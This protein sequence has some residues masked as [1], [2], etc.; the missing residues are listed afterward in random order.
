MMGT[1]KQKR[2]NEHRN[3]RVDDDDDGLV[4]GE[5]PGCS[6]PNDDDE[7]HD[8]SLLDQAP[9]ACANGVDD[10]RDRLIDFH[11]VPPSIGI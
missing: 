6:G 2:Q 1:R 8:R 11:S 7:R 3:G 9:P 5:D 4:D 10:D